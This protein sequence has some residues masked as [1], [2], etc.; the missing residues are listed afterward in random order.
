MT[1]YI[2][3]IKPDNL[4]KLVWLMWFPVG[5][6]PDICWKFYGKPDFST[7]V[8]TCWDLGWNGLEH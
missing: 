3:R 1:A 4:R 7:V 6:F 8:W 5:V 2:A